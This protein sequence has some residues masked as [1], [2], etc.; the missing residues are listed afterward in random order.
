MKFQHNADNF[1]VWLRSYQDTID[2]SVLPDYYS[3][4][5][6]CNLKKRKI[7][8]QIRLKHSYENEKVIINIVK[9]RIIIFDY[10]R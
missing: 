9:Y 5:R 10:L 2:A 3:V 8:M 7:Q 4:K 1:R 6:G